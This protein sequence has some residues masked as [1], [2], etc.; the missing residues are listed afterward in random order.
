MFCRQRPGTC[1]PMPSGRSSPG[2]PAR[3]ESSRPASPRSVCAQPMDHRSGSGRRASNMCPAMKPG[4]LASSARPERRNATSPTCR[5]APTCA[6]GLPPSRHDG[7]A[8]QAHQQMKEEVGLDH[9]R[10]PI[11][12][13]LSPSRAHVDDR[14]RLPPASS[15]RN[16]KR[17]KRINGPPLRPGVPGCA[18]LSSASS[19]DRCGWRNGAQLLSHRASRWR[20]VPP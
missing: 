18:M 11:L 6:R 17:E 8:N 19:C 14:L 16:G 12:A 13:I 1:W 3:R 4:S 15:P 7:S 2:V 9:F 20:C 5:A 10:G